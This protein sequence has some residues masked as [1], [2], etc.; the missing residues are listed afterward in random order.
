MFN[1]VTKPDLK[2]TT[3]VDTV[4][5]A[6]TVHLASLKIEVDNLDIGKKET[7]PVDLTVTCVGF[8][9]VSFNPC[10]KLIRIMLETSHNLVRKNKHI[11]S[12]RKFTF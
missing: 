3:D 5:L 9:V 4:K 12:F 2:K 1:Y 8:L 11:C 7:I 6:E 10:P